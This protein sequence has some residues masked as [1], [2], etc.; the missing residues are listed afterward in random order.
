[1]KASVI[2]ATYGRESCLVDTIR[3]VLLQDYPD[4]ELLV[5]DQ[6]PQH[7]PE[8]EFFLRNVDDPRYSYFL[9]A[10]PSLPAARNF[11]LA[12]SRGEIVIYIDDDVL[13]DR[14][15]IHAH[16]KVYERTER[17]AALG[18][19]VRIPGRPVSTHLFVLSPDGSWTGDFDFPDEGDLETVR[20]CNMSFRQSSLEEIDGFDPS[21]EGNALRE[22]SDVCFRLRR[23]GYQIRF[24][25]GAALDHLVAPS[26]GCREQ[27]MWSSK[28]YYQNEALFYLKN[29]GLWLF[30]LFFANAF[31]NYVW[32]HKRDS[33]FG[34]RLK[35]FSTGTLRGMR[36][37]FFPKKMQPNVVWELNRTGTWQMPRAK[38]E[39]S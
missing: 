32:P 5:V 25:P 19:R 28:I 15:F 18:G 17:I 20:G 23:R 13:L 27:E 33:Q 6:S 1:M 34:P 36:L 22:E 21:Y 7:T 2:I 9:V 31:K 24:E 12:R 30:C 8:V 37:V 38:A 4:F 39:T 16:V 3:S 29:L 26:G 35:A 11:G 14:D 10:P